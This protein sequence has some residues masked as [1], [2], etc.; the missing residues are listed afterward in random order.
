MANT[1][2]VYI[3]ARGRNG[4]L[5]TGVTN[6]LIRRVWEHREGL[7]A[8]FTKQYAVKNAGVLRGAW[9]FRICI[10]RET[11]LQRWRRME[12]RSDRKS[13]SGMA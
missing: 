6:D 10:Q 8:G 2:Y 1:Y 7:V 3:L 5:Y 4:T 13:Q 12:T 9:G 11:P